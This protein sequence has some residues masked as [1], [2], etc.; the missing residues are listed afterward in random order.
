MDQSAGYNSGGGGG[1]ARSTG[2]MAFRCFPVQ[3][4]VTRDE[5][6]GQNHKALA[7]SLR[8][9][10]TCLLEV[11]EFRLLQTRIPSPPP[12]VTFRK[13]TKMTSLAAEQQNCV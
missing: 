3:R 10:V 9:Q 1:R 8:R 7:P 6:S 13:D 11:K 5:R 12:P 2:P 4:A